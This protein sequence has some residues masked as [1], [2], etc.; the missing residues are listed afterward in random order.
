MLH[1]RE[2]SMRS[3]RES[4][5]VTERL[6]KRLTALK[7]ILFVLLFAFVAWND[8][9]A[10]LAKAE[11]DGAK[12][13]ALFR[14]QAGNLIAGH[15]LLLDM[16]ADRVKGLDWDTIAASTS[17]LTELEALD[18]TLDGVSEILLVDSRGK[19]RATTMH[20]QPNDAMPVVEQ[21]CFIALS[22]NEVDSCI[23]P[24]RNE[25][26]AARSLFLLSRRLEK[27]GV[28]DGIAQVAVSGDYLVSQW[29]AATPGPSDVVTMFGADGAVLAQ[30]GQSSRAEPGPAD[31]GHAL[32]GAIGW[33]HS[34]I[35]R[36]PLS[37]GGP[38]RISLYSQIANQ[39]VYISL[40]LDKAA[41]MRSWYRN[42]LVYGLVAA[43]AVVG[44]VVAFGIAIRQAKS[45]R[46]AVGLWEAEVEEREKMEEQLRQ[47][48]KME[49]LGKLTG[50]IAHDFN[51]LLTVIIG[52]IDMAQSLAQDARSRRLLGSALKASRSAATL[53][54]RLLAFARKQ[55]LQPRAIELPHL[56][57]GMQDLLLRTLGPDVRL[58]VNGDIGL[59]PALVDPNQIELAVLNLAVNARDAMPRGGT[60][61]IVASNR[62][63]GPESP[64]DLTSGRYVVLTVSDTG[65]GMD[66]ATLK[67]AAEPFFSTKPVGKGTG[68]GLSMIQGFVAQSGGAMRI[69]SEIGRGTRVEL[70]LPRAFTLP[71]ERHV[72]KMRAGSRG[73]AAILVCDDDPAVLEFVCE[74]LKANGYQVV[75]ASSGRMAISLL[76]HDDAIR[77]LLVDYTM[78]EMNGATVVRKVQTSHREL[79]VLVMTGSADLEAIQAELP[80]VGVLCKPFDRDV[81]IERV[82]ALLQAE[83]R[84]Q[85]SAQLHPQRIIAEA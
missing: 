84:P 69:R 74:A 21:H 15:Q 65:D 58:V 55:I 26:G 40:S 54:Q 8:R 52:N 25:F 63:L 32:I 79:P 17:M 18:R 47:S 48:Q 29:G 50:G 60:L 51:N 82:A 9:S 13:V 83:Q 53:T 28:F 57:D 6:L 77:L 5:G 19:V 14:E 43:T 11:S 78:S 7:L 62:E 45:E 49:G 16:A 75:P 33:L 59:W 46:R 85:F 41:I 68:L 23:S 20:G 22:R 27:D 4:L 30:A 36:A 56:V 10:T 72:A 44:I 34:G 71:A 1:T 64:R 61:S 3:L 31:W 70:W 2:V 66:E 35:V 76:Q 38:D 42:L 73:S 24:P 39:P 81:L 37:A 80:D 67:R 12:I